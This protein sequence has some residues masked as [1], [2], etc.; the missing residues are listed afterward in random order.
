MARCRRVG[1]GQPGMKGHQAGF[2]GKACKG[3]EKR[4]MT[5]S[6]LQMVVH[7]IHKAKAGRVA[8]Q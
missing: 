3:T 6:P 1:I 7:H 5:E 8:S 4:H 2:Q